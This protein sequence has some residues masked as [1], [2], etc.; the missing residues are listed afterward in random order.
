M[1]AARVGTIDARIAG[2]PGPL[3]PCLGGRSLRVATI[4]SECSINECKDVYQDLFVGSWGIPSLF[5]GFHN[6]LHDFRVQS[7]P[8]VVRDRDPQP[9]SSVDPVAPVRSEM[10]K[11]SQ[12]QGPFHFGG[13]PP[14]A[15]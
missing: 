4:R 15:A 14:A 6:L 3:I 12:Q 1:A 5:D 2:P 11:A 7:Q 9:A 8:A 10:F 13:C